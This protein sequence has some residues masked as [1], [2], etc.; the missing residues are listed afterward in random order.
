MNAASP[1]ISSGSTFLRVAVAAAVLLGAHAAL[2]HR[3]HELEV[4]RVEGERE[5]HRLCRPA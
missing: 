2:D 3:V 4:A 1:W 5:V